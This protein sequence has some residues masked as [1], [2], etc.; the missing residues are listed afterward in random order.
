MKLSMVI[1]IITLH[2]C[3]ACKDHTHIMAPV[4]NHAAKGWICLS[5]FSIVNKDI[6]SYVYVARYFR[7][8][9][10]RNVHPLLLGTDE[11][12]LIFK[13]ELMLK[14]NIFH[15]CLSLQFWEAAEAR[16][17]NAN[18]PWEQLLIWYFWTSCLQ[19]D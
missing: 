14:M 8:K 3:L 15:V 16:S 19:K 7:N 1:L 4:G 13:L 5:P 12:T 6:L 11:C 9:I 17:W 10:I 2:F 18:I